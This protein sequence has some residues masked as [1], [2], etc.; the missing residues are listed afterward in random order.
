MN[1]DDYW[2]EHAILE[3][4]IRKYIEDNSEKEPSPVMDSLLCKSCAMCH[5]YLDSTC[6]KFNNL[7]KVEFDKLT[8]YLKDNLL[9][10]EDITMENNYLKERVEYLERSNNRREDEI[11]SLRD[12]LVSAND[13]SELERC[14]QMIDTI[15][16]F[17]FLKEECPLNFGF[18]TGSDELKA[19]DIFYSD[20]G[21]WCEHCADDYKQCWIKYFEELMK[22]KNRS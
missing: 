17:G 16:N 8:K 18:S 12:E 21:E 6:L 2:T 15:L 19:Q 1:G 4:G 5:N 7:T 3:E 10:Y 13:T 9:D 22:I 11:I 20:E 14:S